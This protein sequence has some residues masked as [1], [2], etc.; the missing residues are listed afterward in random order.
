MQFVSL[1]RSK[2]DSSHD[3]SYTCHVQFEY[4]S[5]HNKKQLLTKTDTGFELTIFIKQSELTA[6]QITTI[7]SAVY[8]TLQTA[9]IESVCFTELSIDHIGHVITAFI[10]ASYSVQKVFKEADPCEYSLTIG[11]VSEQPQEVKALIDKHTSIAGGINFTRHIADLP[12]NICTP[13]YLA[14]T[15]ETMA[16]QYGLDCEILNAKEMEDLGMNALLSVAKG[17]INP[18]KLITLE[19]KGAANDQPIVIVGKGVTFDSGGISLKPGAAMDEMKYDM[20]GAAATLGVMQAIAEL[21][22]KVNLT[23]IIPAVENMPAHNASKPGDIVKSMSGQTIEI[24]NTDAEGRL[25]LCD[26]LTY[27]NKYNPKVVID[28]A[29]LTGAVI[30]GLGKHHSGIM[31]NDDA[32]IEALISAGTTALDTAWQLPLDEEFDKLLESN[33]ADMANIGGREAGSITAGCFLARF[34][35]DYTWAHLDIAGTAWVSG[36]NKGATG[37]PV[38]MLCEYILNN[39]R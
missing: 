23:I 4:E 37:R 17:S 12:S 31:G 7:I 9:H 6:K 24:L 29:T 34:T 8:A 13:M 2:P 25:I 16:T 27:A 39:L 19:Y 33:F 14:E 15:A 3:T 21:K 26:A 38:A 20:C 18:P 30:I 36:K 28:V 5:E 32:L 10:T 1:P 22:P 11:L 35:G